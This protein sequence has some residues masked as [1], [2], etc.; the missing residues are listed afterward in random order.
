MTRMMKG[1][2]GL[3]WE[4]MSGSWPDLVRK[5]GDYGVFS[6]EG[7]EQTQARPESLKA[8][9]KGVGCTQETGNHRKGIVEP[10]KADPLWWELLTY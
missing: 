5:L 8:P 1:E 10:G 7:C 2:C 4:C 3:W 9:G 6:V